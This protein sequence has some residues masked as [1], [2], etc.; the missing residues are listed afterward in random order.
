MRIAVDA[1]G[2]DNAPLEIIKG[3][4]MAVKEFGVEITLVGREDEIT[5]IMK[6]EG[7]DKNEFE[8]VHTDVLLTMEDEP[9]S[10][11]REKKDSSMAVA[12]SLL[13]EG[14]CD[15]FVSAGN[16]GAILVG[17]TMIVKRIKG[18]K[19]AA[20]AAVFP[21]ETGPLMVT[22]LG[23]NVEC[24][25]EYIVQ[26]A[27]LASEY[28]KNMFGIENP[29]VG[30]LNNGTE[31]HKGTPLQQE[32]HKLL[33]EADVNF[34]GNVEGR[35]VAFGGCDVIVT[36]GFSGN[37]MLKTY[38][39]IGKMISANVKGMFKKNLLTKIGALFVYK[40]LGAFKK[41]LDYK[42]YGGAPLLGISKPVI[43]AHGSSDAKAFKNAIR[44]AIEFEKSGM[45]NV[46]QEKLS[47][48]Q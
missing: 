17:A 45:I 42:E 20:L 4:H 34:K 48:Q 47:S 8:I 39:G 3:C 33:C 36:D 40:E 46:I 22:D 9:T 19:R 23:A 11:I 24:K 1:H 27:M 44:Q 28:M 7:I 35:D 43:K 10:V 26:F 29:R 25:A 5:E 41:K 6:N 12:F 32:A 15:A 16:S 14:K 21:S 2:G 31:E 13:K 37:I 38:E 18:V 30:L